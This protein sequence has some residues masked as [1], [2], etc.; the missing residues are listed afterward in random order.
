MSG[1]L[2]RESYQ[3]IIAEDIAWLEKLGP[4]CLERRHIALVL[5]ASVRYYYG[6]DTSGAPEQLQSSFVDDRSVSY[7]EPSGI[8]PNTLK[9]LFWRLGRWL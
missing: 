7:V 3:E 8:V 1:K 5:N 4:N 6:T 9:R 2:T